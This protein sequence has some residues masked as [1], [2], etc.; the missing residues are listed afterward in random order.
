MTD[1]NIPDFTATLAEANRKRTTPPSLCRRFMKWMLGLGVVGLGGW[2]YMKFE[3]DWLEVHRETLPKAQFPVHRSF[4]ILHLSDFHVSDKVP[5]SLVEEAIEL[6]LAE[7]PDVCFITGDF[8]TS[9][10]TDIEFDSYR[11]VLSKLSEAVPTFACLGNHDGGQWAGS[12]KGYSTSENVETMLKDTKIHLLQNRR[13]VIYVKGQPLTLVGLGDIWAQR[14]FPDKCLSKVSAD[15]SPQE[16]PV[17]VLSHNPD[18]KTFI[19]DHDW[20]LMLSGHTHGGQCKAPFV[21]YTPFAPV[22]DH[23]IVEGLHNW[24]GR[25]IYVTRGIG[26]LHGL[27]FNCRPQVSI[28]EAKAS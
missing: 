24:Q 6:G 8:I 18:S 17:I 25:L 16:P 9:K 28:L 21:D 26:N 2:G 11:E 27:R 20:Q 10:L 13:Q 19:A 4:R 3:A 22:K 1:E 12:N 23:S 14:C 5:F 7:K 15:R